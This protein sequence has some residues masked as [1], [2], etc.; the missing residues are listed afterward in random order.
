M[1]DLFPI[2]CSRIVGTWGIWAKFRVACLC[3][4]YLGIRLLGFR[5]LYTA[6][7]LRL[8]APR[9]TS[10]WDLCFPFNLPKECLGWRKCGSMMKHGEQMGHVKSS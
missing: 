1:S 8:D 4:V 9:G 10:N 2:V 3:G 5:L 7:T 6:V